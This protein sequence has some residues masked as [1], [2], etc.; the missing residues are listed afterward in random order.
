MPEMPDIPE[1]E[2]ET[3][4][5]AEKRLEKP[6]AIGTRLERILK[7]LNAISKAT[8]TLQKKLETVSNVPTEKNPRAAESEQGSCPLEQALIHIESAMR[9]VRYRTEDMINNLQI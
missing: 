5:G 9:A 6:S 8:E 4:D 1:V 3:F 2:N 7:E